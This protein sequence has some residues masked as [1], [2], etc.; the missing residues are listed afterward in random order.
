MDVQRSV[1][2]RFD[3]SGDYLG[4][5]GEAVAAAR[6]AELSVIHVVVGFRPGHPEVSPRNKSFSAVAGSGR[7]VTGDPGAEIHPDAAPRPEDVIVT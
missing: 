5:L 2:G 4:R 6:A 7:L 1:L 3:T